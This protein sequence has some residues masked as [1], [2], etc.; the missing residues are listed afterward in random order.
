MKND[1]LIAYIDMAKGKDRTMGEYAS[2]AGINLSMISRIKNGTYTPGVKVL[3]KLTSENAKPRGG[4]SFPML[5]EAVTLANVVPVVGTVFAGGLVAAAVA[6]TEI[7]PKKK[8]NS[9][10]L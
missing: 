9:V 5:Y 3:K 2:A 10:D 7:K 8:S 4:I 6:A 1:K